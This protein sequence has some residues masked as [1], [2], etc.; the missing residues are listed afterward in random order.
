[1]KFVLQTILLT[2]LFIIVSD[3][4]S[5]QVSKTDSLKYAISIADEDTLKVELY[6][7]MAQHLTYNSSDEAIEYYKK[8]LDLATELNDITGIVNASV[9]LSQIYSMNGEYKQSLAILDDATSLSEG[10]SSLLALCHS[11]IAVD[12]YNL[13]YEKLFVDHTQIA[14]KYNEEANDSVALS[15][16]FNNIG[17][18]Y[19]E[20]NK[21]DSAIIYLNKALTY[22]DGKTDKLYG[23]IYDGLGTAEKNQKN[24]SK[25]LFHYKRAKAFFEEEPSEYEVIK[26]LHMIA[27]VEYESGRISSAFSSAKEALQRSEKL[28]N[29][30]LLKESSALLSS[31]C[32]QNG[33]YRRSL[34]YARKERAYID[35]LDLKN[36]T[37]LIDALG[38]KHALEL[39]KRNL[40]I[41]EEMNNQLWKQQQFLIGFSVLIVLLLCMVAIGFYKKN[42]EHNV[43]RNLL[44]ELDKLN[45]S[46]RKI[47]G[48]IGHD[49]RD[50]IG[51]LKNF[52]QLMHHKLLD[53]ESIDGLLKKF[54]PMVNSTHNLLENLLLWSQNNTQ[55]F[56]PTCQDTN[57]YSLISDAISHVSHLANTKHICIIKKVDNI[58]FC[59]D[60]NMLLTILRNLLSNSIKFS[61]PDSIIKIS[62]A[63]KADKIKFSVSDNGVGMSKSQINSIL[64]NDN[65]NSTAG[66][67]GEMGSGLGLY[68]CSTLIEKH[69]GSLKIKSK[70]GEGSTFS[71]E[72]PYKRKTKELK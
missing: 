33:Y 15:Y 9:G 58:N 65:H 22:I 57:S 44:I 39:N 2:T 59:G 72:I 63:L 17:S 16:N 43:N 54:V 21:N 52:T 4:L 62:C 37:E 14:R 3:K 27:E 61:D 8:S 34:L 70:K 13:G 69:R 47:L 1:M 28:G 6:R 42:K 49:L 55:G 64:S 45:D 7:E 48:I 35:S 41:S 66:T 5:S 25:A 26:Q 20:V 56:E 67:S 51:N 46:M 50:S 53:N 19:L 11:N 10:N 68:F 40:Q 30:K 24:Y 12:Y 71:F 29:Y 38:T 18:Y 60:R 32:E 31:L 36:N 23:Y